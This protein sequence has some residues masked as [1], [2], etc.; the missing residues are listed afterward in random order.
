[1]AQAGLQMSARALLAFGYDSEAVRDL[2]AADRS[3]QYWLGTEGGVHGKT[4]D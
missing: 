2:I 3:T 4:V 1:M